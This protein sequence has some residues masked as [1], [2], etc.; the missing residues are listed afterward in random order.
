MNLYPKVHQDADV[1][2]FI[3]NFSSFRYLNN[4]D[5]SSTWF[6]S[7]VFLLIYRP[8]RQKEGN[9]PDL[10][11]QKCYATWKADDSASFAVYTTPMDY[12]Q[13]NREIFSYTFLTILQKDDNITNSNSYQLYYAFI[14]LL[15]FSLLILIPL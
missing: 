1:K 5:E 15:V 13:C 9:K 11:K 8:Q 3:Q 14:N 7:I 12:T 4:R 2:S 6:Y 10:Q